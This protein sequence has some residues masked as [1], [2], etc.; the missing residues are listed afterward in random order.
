MNNR[1][2]VWWPYSVR[3][4][5]HYPIAL[6]ESMLWRAVASLFVFDVVEWHRPDRVMQQF[7]MRQH[8]PNRATHA[9]HCM[10]LIDGA[11]PQLTRCYST[12]HS[13]HCGSRIPACCPEGT[14][15]L[16]YFWRRPIF[17]LVPRNHKKFYHPSGCKKTIQVIS[18]FPSPFA[19]NGAKDMYLRRSWSLRYCTLC[20]SWKVDILSYIR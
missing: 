11:A 8:V 10:V 19:R 14:L 1:Q 17:G 9:C 2:F 7:G 6:Q 18:F 12:S 20:K 15:Q 4:L 3:I 13:L 16:P 5:H